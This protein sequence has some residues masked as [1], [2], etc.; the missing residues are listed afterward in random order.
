MTDSGVI[1]A[2]IIATAVTLILLVLY[3]LN[4]NR[5]NHP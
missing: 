4:I 5:K 2:L 3:E 1:P